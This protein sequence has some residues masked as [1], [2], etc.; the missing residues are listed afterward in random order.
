MAARARRSSSRVQ[1][2]QEK[3]KRA[4]KREEQKEREAKKYKREENKLRSRNLEKTGNAALKAAYDAIQDKIGPMKLR[5]H[6]KTVPLS[7]KQRTRPEMYGCMN[8]LAKDG[9]KLLTAC[10]ELAHEA[11]IDVLQPGEIRLSRTT[12]LPMITHEQFLAWDKFDLVQ[13]VSQDPGS[14]LGSLMTSI[15][16]INNYAWPGESAS[17]LVS[18]R[19]WTKY[20]EEN[21]AASI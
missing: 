15:A 3:E 6:R 14:F 4:R 7:L 19:L 1:A 9:A 13:A 5:I 8:K 17:A 10:S 2:T 18:D 11:L 16:T 20:Q 21:L 12:N